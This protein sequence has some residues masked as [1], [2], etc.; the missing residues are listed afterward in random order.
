[1]DTGLPPSHGEAVHRRGAFFPLVWIA[2][3][4]PIM[5]LAQ[6]F[7]VVATWAGGKV[8]RSATKAREI[9]AGVA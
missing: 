7:I 5:K 1:M 2:E 8:R 3:I 4:L 9:S 6:A